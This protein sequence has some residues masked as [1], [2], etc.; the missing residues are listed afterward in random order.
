MLKKIVKSKMSENDEANV[1]LRIVCLIAGVFTFILV[2]LLQRIYPSYSFYILTE[3]M[4]FS[5]VY[6]FMFVLTYVSSFVK[7]KATII[8]YSTY[9]ISSISILF[10]VYLNRANETLLKILLLVTFAVILGMRKISHLMI[11]IIVMLS[12]IIFI[13][14]ATK[15]NTADKLTTLTIFIMFFLL[16][17]ANLRTKL[18]TEKAL[19]TAEDNIKKMAYYDALTGLPNRYMLNRFVS[20]LLNKVTYNNGNFAV[21]FMDLDNFKKI[22]DSLGHSFGDRTLIETAKILKNCVKKDDIVSRYGGDEFVIIL[23]NMDKEESA[24]LVNRIINEISKPILIEG[25]EVYATTSIGI[26]FYPLDG[27]T[28]ET[29]IK[30]ADA[31]MYKAKCNGRNNFCFFV[32]D[33]NI[34]IKRKM[35]LEN[36]LRKAIEKKE[37]YLCY[38]PQVYLETGELWGIEALIRWNHPVLG[39]IPPLEF[40]PIAEETSL[41]ISIGE[42]VLE[43]ACKQNKLWQEAGL[44][45]V[46][47]AVNVS[48]IQLKDSNFVK[49]VSRCLENSKLDPKYLVLELTESIMQDRDNT[50]EVVN[51]LKSLGVKVAID[52]FGTGYSSLSLLNNLS[53]DILKIDSYFI[54]DISIYSNTISIIKLIIEMGNKLNFDTIIE[55]IEQSEQSRIIEENGCKLGQGYLFSK[56]VSVEEVK[57]YLHQKA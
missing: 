10:S 20:D 46:P 13:L 8:L 3:G 45:I 4:A 39:I 27:T 37:L 18:V 14:F 35:E 28:V 1:L 40:I 56:P 9:Y 42:W 50:F 51:N 53:I 2:I 57:K 33:F 19:I 26:S 49:T 47:I 44:D 52:D 7:R 24:L 31:A 41:I 55:G 16:S 48:A 6:L 21:I 43:T 54:K 36:G 38:Q 30:N 29:L 5:G 17:Y 25:R 32:E 15:N 12:S 34:E 23:N 22:N 11:Y